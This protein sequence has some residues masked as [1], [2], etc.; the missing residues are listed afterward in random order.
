MHIVF[1]TGP[2][3]YWV[4]QT[5]AEQGKKVT[6][7]NRTGRLSQPL[8]QQAFPNRINIMAG[9]ATDPDC[10]YQICKG[11]DAVFFCAMP[12]YTHW[13]E[14]FPPLIKSLI[15]GISRAQAPL[16]YGDNLY[17]YG[18]TMGQAMVENMPYAATGHKGKV[19]AEMAN[20]LM[21]AHRAGTINVAIGRASDFYGPRVCNATIGD[22]FFQAVCT[23]KTANLVGDIHQPHSYTYIKD[24][25]KSLV[26]LSQHQQA[27]GQT[28]HVPSA[29]MISTQQLIK[30][31][32]QETG[33][34]IKVRISGRKMIA[35]LGFF[36]AM[37][38]ELKETMYTWEQPHIVDHNKFAQAFGIDVTPHAIAIR[39]TLAWYRRKSGSNINFK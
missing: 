7:V 20:M 22:A 10:V 15:E 32:E 5:L 31:I 23:G 17:M 14:L 1:G 21:Q 25:A 13:P 8:L 11:A 28:W 30:I 35:F 4:A 19:R 33:S 2:L 34:P 6:M 37:I 26:I 29:P 24:F 9:D 16:I 27:F 12:P 39:E 3:G 38:R 36:H 18:N